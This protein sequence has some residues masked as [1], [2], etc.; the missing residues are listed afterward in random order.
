MS[1]DEMSGDEMS[2][3]MSDEQFDW[4]KGILK[5]AKAADHV[6]VFLHHPRWLGMRNEGRGKNYGDDWTKVHNE[7][8]AAGNVS[9]VFAGH[10]HHM[11]YDPKDKI[12]YFSLATVGGHQPGWAPKVGWLHQYHLVTVRKDQVAFSAFP[13]GAVMDPKA[14]TGEVSEQ[15]E[16]LGRA[17][18]VTFKKP[19]TIADDGSVDGA[20]TIIVKNPAKFAIEIEL[21]PTSKDSR[22]LI[23][24]DHQHATLKPGEEKE[25]TFQ[26]KRAPGTFD[27]TARAIVIELGIDLLTDEHR[28]PMT[29][30]NAWDRLTGGIQTSQGPN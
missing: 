28:L 26:V 20:F 5:K 10:I 19:I 25:L 11:R 3:D 29:V 13:V 24:P 27:T 8:V 1:G 23:G 14:I 9:G 16:V 7:L 18:P 21:V 17:M 15:S 22:W 12:E 2:G 6:F 30:S 4:L